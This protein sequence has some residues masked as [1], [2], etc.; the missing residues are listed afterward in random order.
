MKID[1]LSK[2]AVRSTER[3][4]RRVTTLSKQELSSVVAGVEVCNCPYAY[5]T[6]EQT[7]ATKFE[8]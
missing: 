4:D 3:A 5:G 7:L 6:T 8:G 2:D 1:R